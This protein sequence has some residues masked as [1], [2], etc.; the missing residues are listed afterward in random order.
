MSRY[1]PEDLARMGDGAQKQIRLALLAATMQQLEKQRRNKFGAEAVTGADG[2]RHASKGEAR[3]WEELKLMHR[4]GLITD[5]IHQPTFDLAVNGMLICRYR[6][7]AEYY[8]ADGVRTVEDFKG[9][10]TPVYRIK[11]AL[12]AAIHGITITEVVR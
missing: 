9:V 11:R 5:L 7:D 10:R 3:R 1:R 8:T 4:S 12:M 2:K 6:A